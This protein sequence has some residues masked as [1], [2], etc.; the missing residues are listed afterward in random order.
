MLPQNLLKIEEQ[1]HRKA[2]ENRLRFSEMRNLFAEASKTKIVNNIIVLMLA[3]YGIAQ[4]DFTHDRVS[5]FQEFMTEIIAPLQEGST[6][7]KERFDTAVENYIQLV[8]TKKENKILKQKVNELQSTIFSLEQMAKENFRLKQLLQYEQ[9]IERKKVLAQVIGWDSANEFKVLRINRGSS[10]GVKVMDPVITINGLVGYIYQ[11]TEHFSD[12]LTI[13]DPNNR[14]DSISERTRTHG[15]VEGSGNFKCR[16]KYVIVSDEIAVGDKVITAG[17]G[18]LYPKG[19]KIG[20]IT[21]IKKENYGMI[22]EVELTPT[23]DFHKL[24]EV[25]ILVSDNETEVVSENQVK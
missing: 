13:L 20:M 6:T 17:L 21:G 12:V 10:D 5:F 24:E 3:I 18:N 22:Q 15:I 1:F 8:D 2:I 25:L 19:I 14:V 16:L 9:E 23:V 11:T 4:H 7:L